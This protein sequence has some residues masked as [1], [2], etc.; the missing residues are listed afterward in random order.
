M[1]RNGFTLVELLIGSMIGAIV[2]MSVYVA[3]NAATKY[4]NKSNSATSAQ[5]TA[6]FA[7]D[8][9]SRN[10]KMAN[11]TSKYYISKID[12]TNHWQYVAFKKS[13]DTTW[14]AYIYYL[15]TSDT[16]A[17][18]IYVCTGINTDPPY[19]TASTFS[20]AQPLTGDTVSYT[21]LTLPTKRIV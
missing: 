17:R 20:S 16:K 19:T 1:K 12:T 14:T 15:N 10:L 8:H 21:H 6:R 11:S 18:K 3:F 5:Q 2:L 13:T 9:L 4:W 7:S